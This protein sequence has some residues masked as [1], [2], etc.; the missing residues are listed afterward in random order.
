MKYICNTKTN[1]MQLNTNTNRNI[2]P[3]GNTKGILPPE[4]GNSQD[5]HKN[6]ENTKMT[7]M[8][9]K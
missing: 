7:H 8:E 9:F 2:Y 3:I 6:K 1:R 5:A 4:A